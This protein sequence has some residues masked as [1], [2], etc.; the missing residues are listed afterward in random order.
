M[1]IVDGWH[2][3]YKGRV[4][5]QAITLLLEPPEPPSLNSSREGYSFYFSV[6]KVRADTTAVSIDLAYA[7]SSCRF[8]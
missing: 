7:E 6:F 3:G 2:G 1:L 4:R 8:L 5:E